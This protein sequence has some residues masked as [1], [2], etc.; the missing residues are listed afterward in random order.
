MLLLI[1]TAAE[2]PSVVLSS[3]EGKQDWTR[4]SFEKQSH[5]EC[6]PVFIDE[7]F[8]FVRKGKQEIQAVVINQGPGSYTGLR[9]GS[10][11]VKGICY[12]S[13]IPLIAVSGLT[14][15]GNWALKNHP[16]LSKAYSMLDARRNEVYFSEVSLNDIDS[17]VKSLILGED[18]FEIQPN[19]IIVGNSNTKAVELVPKL[20]NCER[21]DTTL[22]AKFMIDIAWSKY[23]NR[24]FEDVAYFEPKYAKEFIPGISKKF[25]V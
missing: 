19:S 4:E 20:E 6:I 16:N 3:G 1:E 17:K 23:Q 7:A 25:S 12:G 8:E 14:A 22:H 11:I 24:V 5:A 13:S 15:Q 21:F 2:F 18:E 10:S 9:I